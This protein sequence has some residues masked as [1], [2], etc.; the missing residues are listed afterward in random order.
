MLRR[1]AHDVGIAIDEQPRTADIPPKGLLRDLRADADRESSKSRLGLPL[2]PI[3]TAN[4]ECLVRRRT[5]QST[6]VFGMRNGG[7]LSL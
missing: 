4:T 1:V 5:L 7:R 3:F 6:L 2:D